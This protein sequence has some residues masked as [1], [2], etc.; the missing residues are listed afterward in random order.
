MWA[1]VG[2]TINTAVPDRG[3]LYSDRHVVRVVCCEFIH[4]LSAAL[5]VLSSAAE[6][7]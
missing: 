3:S 5:P 4:L 6:S 1:F 2:S 7:G